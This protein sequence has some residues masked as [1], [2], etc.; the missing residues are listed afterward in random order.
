MLHHLDKK[1]FHLW[2]STASQIHSS[3][4]IQHRIARKKT[5]SAPRPVGQPTV[6]SIIHS[7]VSFRATLFRFYNLREFPFVS[8]FQ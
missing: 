1:L 7:F 8:F 5:K 2:S 6:I 3:D 4:P